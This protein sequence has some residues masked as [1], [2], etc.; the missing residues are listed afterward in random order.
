M[1]CPGGVT[2]SHPLNATETG[3]KRRPYEP[4][5]SGENLAFL[6]KHNMLFCCSETTFINFFFLVLWIMLKYFLD[7]L[8]LAG[9]KL[10]FFHPHY[11]T[12]RI[13][14]HFINH[15]GSC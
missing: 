1:S 3:D 10:C 7:S 5:G 8:K 4:L 13:Q 6:A 9:A 12:L 2:D 14:I 15:G 11:E